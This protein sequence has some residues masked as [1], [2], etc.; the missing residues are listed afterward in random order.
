[1]RRRGLDLRDA[2][3]VAGVAALSVAAALLARK[4]GVLAISDD[5]FARAAIAEEFARTPRLDPSGTSWL[6]APFWLTGAVM[7]VFGR[8][9]AVARAMH[10]AGAPDSE[11]KPLLLEAMRRDAT[12]WEFPFELGQLLERERDFAGAAAAYEKAIALNAHVPEPHYRLARMYD[13]LRQ[14][15]NAARERRIH[16]K[17]LAQPKEGMR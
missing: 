9:F 2:L 4:L 7:A 11:S 17:L 13:R 16:E 14:P 6:P 8:S 1:M 15:A 3:V 12:V 5:D 10:A